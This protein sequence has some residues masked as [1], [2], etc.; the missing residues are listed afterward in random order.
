[1]TLWYHEIDLW[2]TVGRGVP[3]WADS[4]PLGL[5]PMVCADH[6]RHCDAYGDGSVK[7]L[8]HTDPHACSLCDGWEP[9]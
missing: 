9:R 5:C 4:E 2:A 3:E 1:M 8:G 7:N 6:K